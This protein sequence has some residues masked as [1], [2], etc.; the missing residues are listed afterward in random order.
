VT[1]S[2]GEVSVEYTDFAYLVAKFM[3]IEAK[4]RGGV[5]IESLVPTDADLADFLENEKELEYVISVEAP[6]P[7]P[8]IPTHPEPDEPPPP[9]PDAG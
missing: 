5:A 1:K 9:I 4:E 8:P 7:T 2:H 3:K 6:K